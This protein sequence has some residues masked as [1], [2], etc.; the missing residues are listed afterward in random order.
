MFDKKIPLIFLPGLFGSMSD[1]IV[2]GKG[3][4]SFGVAKYIYDPFILI[5]ES[6]GYELEKNLLIAFYD[7]RKEC[8]YS[9]K[10][11]LYEKIRYTK[12][13]TGSDKVN[14]IGHSMGG[15][16]ARAYV[17]SDY[18][19]NDVKQ[20]IQI[21]TP[22]S[23]TA[24]N[25]SYWAGGELPNQVRLGFNFVRLYM[26]M[27]MLVLKELCKGNEM[28]AIHTHF[29]GLSN[30]IPSLSY[31][32][33]LF[34]KEDEIMKF[35]PI[36]G[37]NIQNDF[38]N[39][40]NKNM[41][42]ISERSIEVTIIAGIGKD[43]INFLEIVPSSSSDRWIDGQVVDYTTSPVGDGSTL[44][45]S[46]FYLD[47]EKYAIDGASHIEVLYKCRHILEEKLL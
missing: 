8:D 32:D 39:D 25:Y 18:Y 38:L 35:K 17:Q 6:L 3:D 43:T 37:M 44:L 47:G 26:D 42:I 21:A 28:N 27:Y 5:L 33:F 31:R 2:P 1:V 16:V 10:T 29:K 46:V 36:Q 40:L 34:Y 22:N 45:K 20:L 19:N 14:L 15:L 41:N 4:W 9:A 23:G 11:Y 13:K 30:I 7:W 24:P 12:E